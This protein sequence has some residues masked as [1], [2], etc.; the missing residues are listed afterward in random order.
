M[1]IIVLGAGAWGT[2]VA[3]SAAQ[4]PAGHAV[5]LWARDAAQAAQMQTQRQNVRYLP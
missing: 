2:A 4:H 3:M 1:K 5:T